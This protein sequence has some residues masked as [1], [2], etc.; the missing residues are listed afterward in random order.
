MEKIEA[1]EYYLSTYFEKDIE[2][3]ERDILNQLRV[4]GAEI[5]K[6]FVQNLEELFEKVYKIQEVD[7]SKTVSYVSCSLLN[8]NFLT[9][10]P[11]FMVEAFDENWFL[12]PSIYEQNYEF[13]WLSKPMYTFYEKALQEQK[14]YVGKIL[15]TDVEKFILLTLQRF[16]KHVMSF[17]SDMIKSY[18]IDEIEE[19]RLLKK[20]NFTLTIGNYRGLFRVLY[21]EETA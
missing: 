9:H 17:L 2:Q 11:L 14:K 4:N 8:I 18:P 1:F 6:E 19:F 13:E 10:K 12:F 3:L 21:E 16:F 7:E 20:E 15:P 5:F